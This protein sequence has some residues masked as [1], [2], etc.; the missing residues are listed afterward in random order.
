MYGVDVCG[1]FSLIRR[2]LIYALSQLDN[3]KFSLRIFV[4]YTLTESYTLF[5]ISIYAL[6][7]VDQLQT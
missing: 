5:L 3:N 1:T 2:V 6:A 4:L 7:M